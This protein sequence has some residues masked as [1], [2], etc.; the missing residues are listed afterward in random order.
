MGAGCFVQLAGIIFG[1]LLIFLI[2]LIGWVLGPI[3]ILAAL[4]W[5]GRLAI[6]YECSNCRNPVAS[7]RVRVCPACSAQFT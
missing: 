6:T 5:G 7:K 4:I 1:L 3:L 2:P